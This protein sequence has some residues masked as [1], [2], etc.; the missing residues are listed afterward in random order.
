METSVAKQ[1]SGELN[2]I[3]GRLDESIR[4]VMDRCHEAEFTAY[5]S[6]IGRVMG[7]LVLDVLNPLYARN[8][9]SSRGPSF[10]SAVRRQDQ[11]CL[12]EEQDIA[13]S[14][15]GCLIVNFC[16]SAST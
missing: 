12:L 5:R 11:S 13:R 15:S 4:L 6:A 14:A 8:P 1:L 2:D 3:I 7:M 16:R 9:E 10:P